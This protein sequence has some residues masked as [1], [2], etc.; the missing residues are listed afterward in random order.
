MIYLFFT[1]QATSMRRSFEL[2]LSPSVSFPCFVWT[3]VLSLAIHF[4]NEITGFALIALLYLTVGS[5][6]SDYVTHLSVFLSSM[7]KRERERM[8]HNKDHRQLSGLKGLV[9]ER[10]LGIPAMKVTERAQSNAITKS[11][12]NL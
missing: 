8:Q 12:K 10:M 9:S 3:K 2:S 5:L 4:C 6:T 1:K 11:L 7:K